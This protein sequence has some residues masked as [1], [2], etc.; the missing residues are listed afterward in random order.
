MTPPSPGAELDQFS[1]VVPMHNASAFILATLESLG[2]QTIHPSEVIVID[3][4]STDGCTEIVR[5]F[6]FPDGSAPTLIRHENPLGV[7]MARNHGAYLARSEWIGFCD[8]DD[9]WHP[10]RIETVLNAAATHPEALAIATAATGFALE[11]DL[12]EL[13]YHQRS[14]M[15]Q[16]WVTSDD[17]DTL[18]QRLA[19]LTAPDERYLTFADFRLSPCL[20]TTSVCFRRS[21]YAMAG[22]HAPWCDRADDWVL[23][24]VAAHLAP[25]LYLDSPLIFYRIRDT[26]QSH[27]DAQ[28][29]LTLLAVM[30]ALRF[31]PR[32]IDRR[33]TG[34]MYRHLLGVEARNGAPLSRTLALAVLGEL[35]PR[36][37]A[38]LCK[39]I[40]RRKPWARH[41]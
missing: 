36:Q 20:T 38:S 27:D 9:L 8:N 37:I 29:A 31:G 13:R 25:I 30:L 17:L 14:A 7:A 10:L 26:A 2:A 34:L 33:P 4:G 28:S 5:S 18:V 41:F 22:G 12:S 21:A 19:D 15:V 24:A 35:S 32:E 6:R 11:A 16:H 3:D 1:V 39:T 23:N 40:L